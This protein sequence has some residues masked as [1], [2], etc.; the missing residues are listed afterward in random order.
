MTPR[1]P[2]VNLKSM[3]NAMESLSDSLDW[4]DNIDDRE[5]LRLSQEMKGSEYN[6]LAERT[7]SLVCGSRYIQNRSSAINRL[8]PKILS[9]IFELLMPPYPKIK[10][11]ITDP[12]DVDYEFD[13]EA[14]DTIENNSS[15]SW[16]AITASSL[17]CRHWRNIALATP[18][19]WTDIL[20]SSPDADFVSTQLVRSGV[21]PLNVQ[22]KGPVSPASLELTFVNNLLQQA[23]R[24]RR[25]IVWVKT[26]SDDIRP[27][28][29]NA[30]QLETLDVMSRFYKDSDMQS[31][32]DHPLLCDSRTPRLHTLSV[33]N[34]GRWQTG[35][36]RT[37]RYLML[38][39]ERNLLLVD[40]ADLANGLMAVF[41]ANANTLEEI[42]MADGMQ[43]FPEKGAA[44]EL[45]GVSPVDMRALKRLLV[46]GM[47]LYHEV[48]EPKL[49]LHECA[50]DYRFS[51]SWN[52]PN[53]QFRN[54]NRFPVKKLFI[55]NSHT[56]ATNGTLAMRTFN[57]DRLS[58]LSSFIDK[59]DVQE[60]WLSRWTDTPTG[61]IPTRIAS[62]VEPMFGVEKLV[63][64][65]EERLW[66]SHIA[67]FNLFPALSELQLHSQ[68]EANYPTILDF[69][70]RR[71]EDGRAIKTLRFVRDPHQNCDTVDFG[72]FELRK[73]HL[74]S[75][76]ANVVYDNV[77][78]GSKPPRMTL[79]AVC[80]TK[81]PVH[82]YWNPWE[83]H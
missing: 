21:C 34:W 53:V 38:S 32:Q 58:L 33:S 39:F 46:C 25:L 81:S 60:L 54:S 69:V 37:L 13:P 65:C 31:F 8:P 49:V 59:R 44:L 67:D 14:A 45:E 56:A 72:T 11:F 41:A 20:I 57:L 5:M 28:L 18:A 35:T 24:I 42:T 66:L 74:E 29:E 17:V 76:V 1:S 82:A 7:Q 50:R 22:F 62:L 16:A 79:P 48:I 68:V 6:L 36:F 4:L 77:P 64:L 73:A 9:T 12:D 61:P 51:S 2:E 80:T 55:S 83:L 78:D 19:L 71:N 15:T 27:W 52:G 26:Q 40:L 47:Q 23:H 10:F 3:Q 70:T 43:P 30:E 63:I 75:Y